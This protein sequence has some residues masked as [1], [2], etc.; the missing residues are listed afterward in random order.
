MGLRRPTSGSSHTRHGALHG[1]PPGG[2]STGPDLPRGPGFGVPAGHHTAPA[3]S[4][5][6]FVPGTADTR[7][8][9]RLAAGLAAGGPGRICRV[10]SGAHAPGC[11]CYPHGPGPA[12]DVTG[13]ASTRRG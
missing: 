12:F 7:R 5:P 2:R 3:V 4:I 13:T 11:L 8:P 6:H 9:G 1:P 10:S